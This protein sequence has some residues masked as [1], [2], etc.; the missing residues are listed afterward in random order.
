MQRGSFWVVYMIL[1]FS[2]NAA[3]ASDTTAPVNLHE[4]HYE[5]NLNSGYFDYASLDNLYADNVFSGGNAF[6]G[7]TCDIRAKI[8]VKTS[9][10]LSIFKRNP[11]SLTID[12]TIFFSDDRLKTIKH[13]HFE[14]DNSYRFQVF[15]NRFRY[16]KFYITGDW[17]TSGD[18]VMND[19]MD[20]ELLMSSISPGCYIEYESKWLQV[21]TQLLSPL[22]SYTCRNSY[23][24]ARSSDYEEFGP[25]DFM[26]EYSRIQFPNSLVGILF[27]SGCKLTLSKNVGMNIEYHFR[28]LRNSEP[29]ILKV[30]TGIYSVGLYYKVTR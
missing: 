11:K 6:W 30:V 12:S 5:F 18:Y 8:Y 15:K 14:L 4:H 13:L 9:A 28:Y 22:L 19:Y 7:I 20:P 3:F 21:Y 29:R 23:S 25:S 17:F 16:V 1:I 27:H 24:F 26:R 2:T 10:S